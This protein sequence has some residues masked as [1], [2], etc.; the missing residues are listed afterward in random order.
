[1]KKMLMALV[2]MASVGASAATTINTVMSSVNETVMGQIALNNPFNWVVGDTAVYN[3]TMATFIKGTMTMTIKDVQPTTVTI[4]QSMDLG[5]AGK[6]DCIEVID[7]TTGAVKSMVCNGQN[8]NP[9]DTSDVT[10]VDSKED[11]VTVPA[12]TFVCLY[13]KAHSASQ[14]TDMEQWANP[15]LVPVMGLVKA[16]APSQ[17]GQVTIELASFKKM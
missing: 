3:L 5:F 15:K 7:S 8:Q 10:V 6:Q 17:I 4:D 1:M 16:L 9:G 11:T 2:M 14:N 12:G 13:I